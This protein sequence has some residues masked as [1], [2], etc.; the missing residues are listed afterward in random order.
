MPSSWALTFPILRME[1]WGQT[2]LFPALGN[3]LG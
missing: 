3:K 2:G 1:T